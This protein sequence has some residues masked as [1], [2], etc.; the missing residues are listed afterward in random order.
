[1]KILSHE[2][3]SNLNY[4]KTQAIAKVVAKKFIEELDEEAVLWHLTQGLVAEYNHE[5]WGYDKYEEDIKWVNDMND[6]VTK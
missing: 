1:M 4:T 6:V 5:G 2:E 3:F